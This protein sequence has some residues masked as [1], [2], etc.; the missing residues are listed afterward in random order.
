MTLRAK[1]DFPSGGVPSRCARV[2]AFLVGTAALQ[3][4]GSASDS[5][6]GS[7]SASGSSSGS[8][9]ASGSSSGSGSGSALLSWTPPT[10]RA[11]GTAIGNLMG[12]KIYYGTSPDALT[13][14][15][16]VENAGV[17]SYEIDNIPPST[18]YFA[19]TAVDTD[20]LESAFSNIVSK[21]IR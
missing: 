19:V 1:V 6:S 21:V 15:V 9:S 18:Y 2:L 13:T 20:R 8:G 11:D 5:P 12:Y 17:A 3:A 10:Q 4:C 16:T 14:V 7:A